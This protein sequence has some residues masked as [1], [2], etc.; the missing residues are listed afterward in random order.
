MWQEPPLNI[1][2]NEPDDGAWVSANDLSWMD[3]AVLADWAALRPFTELEFEKA[4]RGPVV[5]VADEFAWGCWQP[6]QKVQM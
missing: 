1:V 4:A 5:P 2:V 3:G 6:M